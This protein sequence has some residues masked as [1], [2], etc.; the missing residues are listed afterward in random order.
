M[1]VAAVNRTTSGAVK[2]AP[3]M[4][5]GVILAAGT[6]TSTVTIYNNPSAGSGDK[7]CKLTAVANTSAV[8]VFPAPVVADKGIYCG[9]TGSG[10]MSATVYYA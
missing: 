8:V 4:L 7:I 6:A 3:G 2:A 5:C 1:V 10:G 9:V